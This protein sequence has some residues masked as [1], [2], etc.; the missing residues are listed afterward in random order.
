[1]GRLSDLW[2][3]MTTRRAD[4][5]DAAE[6]DRLLAGQPTGAGRVGVAAL[7]SEASAAARPDELVGESAAV[8][9]YRRIRS[10]APSV[11]DS[12]GTVLSI[13]DLPGRSPWYGP[14]PARTAAIRV[15]AGVVV[16]SAIGAA[17]VH[18]GYI[19]IRI[20]QVPGSVSS[21]SASVPSPSPST[22]QK[23]HTPD[24][25]PSAG[26]TPGPSASPTHPATNSTGASAGASA[27]AAATANAAAPG[28]V[29]AMAALCQTWMDNRQDK[30][31]RDEVAQQLQ[32]LMA[33][34]DGPNGIPAF[35]RKLLDPTSGATATGA[36][37]APAAATSAPATSATGTAS[38]PGNA[39][40]TNPTNAAK[41]TATAPVTVAT[42]NAKKPTNHE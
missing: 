30:A 21:S 19:P 9:D 10:A 18:F 38:S 33:A 5:I 41:K 36:S 40:A 23:Q 4:R 24:N 25:Q 35:C 12:S 16:L 34:A 13:V 27:N 39:T 11:V 15:A 20:Q 8:E 1:M 17:S 14:S 26:A 6:A 29:A 7:L 3:A 2:I 22:I 42:K 31:V 37:S 28:D 32:P